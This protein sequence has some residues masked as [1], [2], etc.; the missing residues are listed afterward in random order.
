MPA[1]ERWE[2]NGSGSRKT[3]PTEIRGLASV[4]RCSAQML[5]KPSSPQLARNLPEHDESGSTMGIR[6]ENNA[7]VDAFGWAG[8]DHRCVWERARRRHAKRT[9]RTPF[10]LHNVASVA[11]EGVEC[12]EC[13]AETEI[14]GNA[15]SC[16]HL[17]HFN[18][19]KKQN[20]SSLKLQPGVSRAIRLTLKQH[21]AQKCSPLKGSETDIRRRQRGHREYKHTP[22]IPR[23]EPA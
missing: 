12:P 16:W 17:H 3:K 11:V 18:R 8:P 10:H 5:S 6:M 4:A 7:R 15:E 13:T 22:G 21:H 1:Q 20:A 14:V 2:R 23:C 9:I 19:K